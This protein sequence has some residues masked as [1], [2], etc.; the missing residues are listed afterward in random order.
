MLC[1]VVLAMPDLDEAARQGDSAFVWT[2]RERAAGM[3]CARC[4]AAASS[5]PSTC[6]AWRR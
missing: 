6:A 3:A 5:S 4:C 1:A 2:M